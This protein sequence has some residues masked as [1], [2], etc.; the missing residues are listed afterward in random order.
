[1]S[2]NSRILHVLDHNDGLPLAIL[3]GSLVS[4]WRLAI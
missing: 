1:M 3:S 2:P 4:G